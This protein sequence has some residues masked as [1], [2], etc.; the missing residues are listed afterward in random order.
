MVG[1]FCHAGNIISQFYRDDALP[2]HLEAILRSDL[3]ATECAAP[4]RLMFQ[5][6]RY[7]TYRDTCIY[8][9]LAC[10]KQIDLQMSVFLENSA[11]WVQVEHKVDGN[12]RTAP[13]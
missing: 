6:L 11:I 9:Q 8:V 1:D 10:K 7:S 5:L 13:T 3:S 12:S 4:G 2:S